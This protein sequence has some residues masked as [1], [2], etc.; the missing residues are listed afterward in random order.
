MYDEDKKV[1]TLKDL[2]TPWT[3]LSAL[4]NRTEYRS[5]SPTPPRASSPR[6]DRSF[7]APPPP[8]SSSPLSSPTALEPPSVHSALTT[9][10]LDDSPAK[11]ARQPYNHVC[12]PEY[13][14]ETRAR[15]LELLHSARRREA[16]LQ[17]A[18]VRAESSSDATPPAEAE[19]DAPTEQL[20]D[21]H[22]EGSNKRKRKNKK[23]MK[24]AAKRAQHAAVDEANAGKPY[25]ETLLA[26]VGV[27][28]AVREQRNVAA[29]IRA[30]GLWGPHLSP[31]S[32]ETAPPPSTEGAVEDSAGAVVNSPASGNDAAS[33]PDAAQANVVEGTTE[34][35]TPQ[36][37]WFEHAPTLEFWVARGRQALVNLGIPVEH[38]I[39]R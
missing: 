8:S 30:G 4:F 37:L 34:E 22:G 36:A 25:D 23:E 14:A 3:K 21:A 38:G 2:T 29:W 32:H 9:L 35:K 13:S 28:D 12:L 5:R 15:D 18:E 26:V 10:L 31:L 33:S 1:Q 39:E 19:P 7:S 17:D 24:Q 16:E 20:E 6:A 27:L 11:A